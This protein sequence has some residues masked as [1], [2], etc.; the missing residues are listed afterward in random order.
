MPTVVFVP[1]ELQGTVSNS[2]RLIGNFGQK[3]AA[4]TATSSRR[5]YPPQ[6]QVCPQ[7]TGQVVH[8]DAHTE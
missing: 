7:V 6:G 8:A 4:K 3:A 1:F 5:V 2:V